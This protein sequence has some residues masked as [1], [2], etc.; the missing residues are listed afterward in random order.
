[1]R[2]YEGEIDPGEKLLMADMLLGLCESY[3]NTY[4][5][6]AQLLDNRQAWVEDAY[7]EA[8]RA[9]GQALAQAQYMSDA[10]GKSKPRARTPV[11]P[12]PAMKPANQ[13]KQKPGLLNTNLKKQDP[14]DKEKVIEGAQALGAGTKGK[15][16]AGDKALALMKKYGLTEAEILAVRTYT[17]ADYKYIN[18]AAANSAGWMAGS[19]AERDDD[20]N[21]TKAVSPKDMAQFLEE[22]SLHSGVAMM[23]LEKLPPVVA[24]VY[25]GARMTP[26]EF[27]DADYFKGAAYHAFTSTSTDED[28]ALKFANGLECSDANKTISV[29]LV[30]HVNN[31]RDI[32][33][34]SL[35]KSEAELLLLPGTQLTTIPKSTP[36]DYKLQPGDR[37]R[38]K[39][40]PVAT[41]WYRFEM[42]QTK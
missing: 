11:V 3:L 41:E 40:K 42:T 1:M 26:K 39:G 33:D 37:K 25:R 4:G 2:A 21:I 27:A 38:V 12:N 32:K 18:P 28:A 8:R 34:L 20:G 7:A 31:A 36:D 24:T 16:G 19:K 22:G 5:S 14:R 6:G 9:R 15:A 23:A 13:P 35:V 29:M 10:Y 17:A 30:L